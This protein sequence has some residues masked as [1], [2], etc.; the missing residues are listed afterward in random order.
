MFD[1]ETSKC[2]LGQLEKITSTV[3]N[4]AFLIFDTETITLT[5]TIMSFFLNYN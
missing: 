5:I 4:L 1:T 2:Y 3:L